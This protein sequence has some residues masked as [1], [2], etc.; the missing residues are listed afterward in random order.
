MPNKNGYCCNCWQNLRSLFFMKFPKRQRIFTLCFRTGGR[1]MKFQFNKPITCRR[2][3]FDQSNN[4]IVRQTLAAYC[5]VVWYYRKKINRSTG[6]ICRK[7]LFGIQLPDVHRY[8]SQCHLR[9][10]LSHEAHYCIYTPQ[11]YKS[12]SVLGFSSHHV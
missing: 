5:T 2:Q 6:H 12:C 11:S 7:K 8:T 1:G 10:A 3:P 4:H 9:G